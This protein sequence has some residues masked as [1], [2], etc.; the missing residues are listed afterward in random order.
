[1]QNVSRINQEMPREKLHKLGAENLSLA[2]LCTIILGVGTQKKSAYKLGKS[3]ASV[4]C[5][6][7]HI[8][9]AEKLSSLGPAQ[10]ARFLAS[11]ELGRR[12]FLRISEPIITPEIALQHAQELYSAKKEIMIGLY[13]DTRSRIIQKEILAVGGLNQTSIVPR[14]VLLPLKEHPEVANLLLLHNHPSGDPSPSQEDIEFTHRIQEMC[15]ILGIQLYD[16]IIS[17]KD[18]WKSLRELGFLNK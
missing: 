17:A 3:I 10:S 1:M 12:I 14:D 18:Q 6:N 8:N 2:E 11:I 15:F 13:L 7:P 4:F 16:H 9:V 5:K